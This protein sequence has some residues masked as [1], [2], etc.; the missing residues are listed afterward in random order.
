MPAAS[1]AEPC[2]ARR[3]AA[4]GGVSFRP[5]GRNDTRQGLAG[6]EIF[7]DIAAA[8]AIVRAIRETLHETPHNAARRTPAWADDRRTAMPYPPRVARLSL[9]AALTA[10]LWSAPLVFAQTCVVTTTD[11]SALGAP[12]IPGSLR[13][14]LE[15]GRSGDTI[16]FDTAVFDLTNSDAA[17]TVGVQQ[18]LPAL[19]DG[20]VTIDASDR[21]VTVNGSGT[22]D[23]SGIVIT[24]GGNV[25]RGLA[26]VDFPKAGLVLQ[27]GAGNVI[28]GN[29]TT[30]TGPNGQGLRI[31][32]NGTDGIEIAGSGAAS[33]VV[34]GCWIGLDADGF[35]ER[36]NLHAGVVIENGATSTVIGGGVPGEENVIANNGGSGI[37]VRAA[38]S[39]RNSARS[40]R[41][42][43]NSSGGIKLFDG[44]NDGVRPPDIASIEDLGPNGAGTGS[45]FRVT[46][47]TAAPGDVELFSDTG[48]Q[49]ATLLGR[50]VSN[51]AWTLDVDAGALENVTATF[52]DALDNTSQFG[53]FG[54]TAGDT[55]G[56]GVSDELEASAGTDPSDPL[57]TPAVVRTLSVQKLGIALNFAKPDKDSIKV[58]ASLPLPSTFVPG[59]ATVGIQ[60]AGY[61]EAF[62]LDPKG[63]GESTNGKIALKLTKAGDFTLKFGL[64]KS[65]LEAR[66]QSFG[67]LDTTTGKA[68]RR[69]VLPV[70]VTTDG[71][72]QQTTVTVLYKA[73]QGKS[74]KT[75]SP[76]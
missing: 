26:I 40:N 39:R 69:W 70:A 14:C 54:L 73:T 13:D 8:T 60:V 45:T 75:S 68:G 34:K 35:T 67:L 3:S 24:S 33:N 23:A 29:R 62:V 52:T 48:D 15:R 37:E 46:G 42:T 4:I 44:S 17:T 63:K 47:T 16:T 30:G 50:T 76:K 18:P 6:P 38:T 53:V 41:I 56:D 1:R 11:D 27:G 22:V 28:G 5:V 12:T 57:D 36:P 32:G 59:G 21:R 19:D 72:V 74:G 51:G 31:S 66:L 9:A 43:R 2:V 20:N 64:K 55:D 71:V 25:I 7:V 49:G 58:A 61:A 10:S 65:E